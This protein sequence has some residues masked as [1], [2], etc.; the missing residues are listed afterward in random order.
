MIQVMNVRTVLY[1][2]SDR[3]RKH[4]IACLEALPLFCSDVVLRYGQCPDRGRLKCTA[5][6]K[7]FADFHVN[8][9]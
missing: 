7:H 4:K 6:S 1:P 8:Q 9:F 3:W 5:L 2:S